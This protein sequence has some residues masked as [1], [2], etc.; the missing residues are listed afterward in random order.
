MAVGYLLLT[1]AAV[2][3][4]DAFPWDGLVLGGIGITTLVVLRQALAQT[5][6]TEAAETDALTGLANR[7]RLHD[8]LARSLRRAARGGQSLAVLL[9]DLNGFKQVN[10]TLGHQAG[11]DLLIA[12]AHAMRRTVRHDDLVG[13]LGGDEFAVIVRS[14]SDEAGALAVAQRLDE[15]IAG[16]F[17]IGNRPVS[18]SASI[19]V[20][21]SEPGSLDLDE[22]LH[23]ADLA[24][25]ARK[26]D[27][28]A[29][30]E[31]CPTCGCN[32]PA[33]STY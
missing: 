33:H 24:M 17:V 23:R 32:K 31:G 19:G 30:D 2:R 15:A 3:E 6:I 26:R 20:A 10:D 28:R 18:A 5:E 22:L 11:D 13:R 14:V 29:A 25:Y 16:P 9:L 27:G 12:V 4:K 7:A 1:I 21:V 8:E